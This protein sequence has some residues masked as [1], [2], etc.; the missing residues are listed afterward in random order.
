M[1]RIEHSTLHFG[2]EIGLCQHGPVYADVTEIQRDAV[3]TRRLQRGQHQM[4]D[5]DIRR[6]AVIPIQLRTQLYR[7]TGSLR[8]LR[9]GM[10]NRPR[11]AQACHGLLGQTVRV[12][13]RHLRRNV[14]AH[15]QRATA[16]LV[17]K[18]KGEQVEVDQ[19]RD[20]E[21]VAPTPV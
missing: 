9:T 10:Q 19:R 12:D 17:S 7:R 14:C 1:Q 5:L 21:P 8:S 18:F 11:V 4:D 13:A 6:N 16:Q 20:D 2:P 15:A 3:K